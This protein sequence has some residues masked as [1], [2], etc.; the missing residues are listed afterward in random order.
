MYAESSFLAALT[1]FESSSALIAAVIAC[2]RVLA[3]VA[4]ATN[5]ASNLSIQL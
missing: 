4:E 1:L 3:S 5:G 2:I